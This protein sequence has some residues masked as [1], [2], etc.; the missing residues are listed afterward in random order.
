MKLSSNRPYLIQAM[1]DWI[2][3]NNLTPYILVKADYPQVVV[4]EKF[5]VDGKIILNIAP[6]AI[7]EFML[8]ARVITFKANFSG[9]RF[10]LF[11]PLG[12]IE[13]I[14]AHENGQGLAL[15]EVDLNPPELPDGSGEQ[16]FAP[17]SRPSKSPAKKKPHLRVVRTDNPDADGEK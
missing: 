15:S 12:A 8:S 17:L 14:Y 4:P 11:I 5:I 2:I 1:L 13:V 9:E 16:P 10:E 3:D 7:R 6:G